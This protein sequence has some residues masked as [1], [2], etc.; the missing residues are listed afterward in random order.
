MTGRFPVPWRIAELPNGFAIEDAN[1]LTNGASVSGEGMSTEEKQKANVSEFVLWHVSVHK[2]L[3]VTSWLAPFII[4]A[5]G[6]VFFSPLRAQVTLP[7]QTT[8]D[9]WAGIWVQLMC[10]I[11]WLIYEIWYTTHRNAA[12]YDLQL[13]AAVDLSVLIALMLM[14]GGM[15]NARE[16]PWFIVVPTVGQ[17]IDVFQSVLLGINNAAEKPYVPTKGST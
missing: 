5:M 3:L 17:V 2:T 7:W 16:L 11:A 12:V 1:G 4:M 6:Y 14:V 13:D 15:I 9:I 10:L 8:S